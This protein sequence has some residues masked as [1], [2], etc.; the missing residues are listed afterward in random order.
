MK[1]LLA[2]LLALTSAQASA[3]DQEVVIAVERAVEAPAGAVLRG[4]DRISGRTT[5]IDV[6]PGTP[7]IYER[8]EIDLDMCKYPKG[9]EA[10]EAFA[11]LRIRDIRENEPA[12]EGWMFGSSP[13]LSAL[14][15]PRYDVWVINCKI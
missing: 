7:V 3:Q 11:Y 8:L 12:F 1:L 5:D 2:A 14:D 13:A 4:L 10:V 6:S 15:H 9:Q